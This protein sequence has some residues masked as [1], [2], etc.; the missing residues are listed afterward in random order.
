MCRSLSFGGD[1]ALTDGRMGPVYLLTLHSCG[2]TDTHDC[3]EEASLMA[4]YQFTIMRI[5]RESL[6]ARSELRSSC[7]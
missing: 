4:L 7:I 1:T 2:Y 5:A 6:L 3:M